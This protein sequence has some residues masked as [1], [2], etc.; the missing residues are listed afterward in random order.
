M[1]FILTTLAIVTCWSELELIW[2][3]LE[4]E[5]PRPTSVEELP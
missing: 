5:A 1:H 4:G 2:S 3:V